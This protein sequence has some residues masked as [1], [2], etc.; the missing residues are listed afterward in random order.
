MDP[1]APLGRFIN[2]QAQQCTYSPG[3][4]PSADCGA[5]ATWHILWNVDC[6]VSLACDQHMTVVHS[7]Y[8]FVDS[9]RI[10]PDCAMPGAL[11]DTAAKRCLYPDEPVSSTAAAELHTPA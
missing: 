2:D 11:W 5:P 3:D 1:F 8:V 9:H 7:R 10:G 4:T 6:E